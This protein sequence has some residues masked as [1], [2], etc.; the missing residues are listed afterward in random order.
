MRYVIIST[1]TVL[2]LM[3]PTASYIATHS[4][5][6][7]LVTFSEQYLHTFL[8]VAILMCIATAMLFQPICTLTCALYDIKRC[9]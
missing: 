2:W 5:L 7:T 6:L 8:Y 1:S 9:I 3:L 4:T